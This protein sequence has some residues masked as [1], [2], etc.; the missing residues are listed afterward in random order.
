[1]TQLLPHHLFQ[2]ITSAPPGHVPQLIAALLHLLLLS[3]VCGFSVW[4]WLL[5]LLPQVLLALVEVL[6]L[7][8][9]LTAWAAL[10]VVNVLVDVHG[11]CDGAVGNSMGNEHKGYED[12]C[13]RCELGHCCGMKHLL[14]VVMKCFGEKTWRKCWVY[15]ED[16]GVY[17]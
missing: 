12:S 10:P 8:K 11:C 6:L 14:R 5:A 4:L 17:M 15:I 1:M 7:L 13:E 3:T 2:P 16:L 9:L